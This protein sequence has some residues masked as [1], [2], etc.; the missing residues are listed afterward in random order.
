MLAFNRLS[1]LEDFTYHISL[2]TVYL[3]I[4]LYYISSFIIVVFILEC[5]DGDNAGA[6]NSSDER[7]KR[8]NR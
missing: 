8:R 2:G 3:A 5:G 6:G 1:R 7:H 4:T